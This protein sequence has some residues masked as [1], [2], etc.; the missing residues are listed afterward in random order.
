[1]LGV[2]RLTCLTKYFTGLA[3]LNTED[4]NKITFVLTN[5][6]HVEYLGRMH[7]DLSKYAHYS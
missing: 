3:E 6:Y 2:K 1:M 5:E 4:R 7:M